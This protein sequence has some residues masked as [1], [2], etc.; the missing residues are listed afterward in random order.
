MIFILVGIV[1]IPCYC[2]CTPFNSVLYC[3][4]YALSATVGVNGKWDLAHGVHP[5][6]DVGD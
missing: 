3:F 6:G 5:V 2:I 1:H 4:S